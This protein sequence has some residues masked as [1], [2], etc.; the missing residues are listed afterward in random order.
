MGL[1]QKLQE[2][3]TVKRYAD[4][5]RAIVKEELGGGTQKYLGHITQAFKAGVVTRQAP[6][7]NLMRT[8]KTWRACRN[9]TRPDAKGGVVNKTVVVNHINGDLTEKKC[10]ICKG[11]GVVFN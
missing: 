10:A 6:I 3:P 5:H 9:C 7:T 8:E 1:F 2:I 4:F 11:K